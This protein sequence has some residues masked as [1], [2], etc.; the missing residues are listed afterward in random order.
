MSNFLR[1]FSSFAATVIA[2]VSQSLIV[3]VVAVPPVAH[4]ANGQCKWEGGPGAPTYPSCEAEDCANVGGKAQCTDAIFS[5]WTISRA[6]ASDWR[7]EAQQYLCEALQTTGGSTTCNNIP[8]IPDGE[9]PAI[10]TT[11]HQQINTAYGGQACGSYSDTGWATYTVGGLW[12]GDSGTPYVEK[13]GQPVHG[14]RVLYAANDCPSTS[15]ALIG[16]RIVIDRD[17]KLLCPSDY[18]SRTLPNGYLACYIPDCPAGKKWSPVG[19]LCAPVVEF[20]RRTK[21]KEDCCKVGN[22]IYPLRGT[23]REVVDTGIE[24]AGMPFQLTYDSARAPWSAAGVSSIYNVLGNTGDLWWSSFHRRYYS[25]AFNVY[26]SFVSRGDG[27]VLAFS[28]NT[29]NNGWI[30][31]GDI[32]D[33]FAF[34]NSSTL[35]FRDRKE[36]AIE[37]MNGA[38]RLT[39]RQLASG[40]AYTYTYSTTST[41]PNIAPGVNYLLNVSDPFGHKVSF[42]YVTALNGSGVI[43]T[44]TDQAGNA[45]QFSYDSNSNLVSI[46]WPD[47]SA[48]QFVYENSSHPWALT[49]IVDESAQR[50]STFGYDGFG[51]A[52]S[53]EHAG[54][55]EHYNVTYGTPPTVLVTETYDSAKKWIWRYRDWAPPADTVVTDPLGGAESVN[56]AAVLG[57]ARATSFAQPGTG[58]TRT[59]NYDS[60]A[61]ITNKTDFNGNRTCSSYLSGRNL[62]SIRI[63][64]L[65]NGDTCPADLAAYAIPSQSLQ[66][67]ITTQWHPHWDF[68]TRQAEPN[69][70][71]T[72][73]Y[74][75][76]PDPTNNNV[77]A[78]CAPSTPKLVDNNV[79]VVLCKRVEQPTSDNTGTLG[80]SVS[81]NGT[82]R[83]W[84]YTY[85]QHGRVLIGNGP[86]T[87]VS[88]VTT[89]T[90]YSCTTG[91]QCGQ[92]AT[93][94]NA[95]NQTTTYNTY[96]AFGKP[97]TITDPN[98]VVTTLTY[99]LRQ[100]LTSRL[101]SGELTSFTYFPTGLLQRVTLP[102]ETYLEYGYDAAHRL[103]SISDSEGNRIVYTL[104]ASSNRTAEQVYD[105]SNALTNTRSRVF[106]VLNRVSQELSSVGIATGFGYDANGNQTSINAP[107]ARNSESQYDE[108]NRLTQVTDPNSGATQF[109]Y[110]ALDQLISV[111]DPSYHV[112]S[113]TYNGL[114]D[115]T[116]Q[117]SPDTGTTTNTYDSAGNVS[118]STDARNQT[119]SY[120][121]DALNRVTQ[122][123]YSDQTIQYQYDQ[124]TNAKGRLTTVTDSSGQTSWTYDAQGRP[125]SHTQVMGSIQ[126]NVSYGYDSAGHLSTVTLPSGHSVQ[127]GYTNGKV[128]SLTLDNTQMILNTVLYEPFGPIRQWTWGNGTL[129][130]RSFDEDGNL[131]QLDSAGSK[132]LNYDNAFR[133]TNI[134]DVTEPNLSQSYN[135]DLLDRLTLASGNTLNQSWSYDANGNRLTQGGSDA[136][137]FTVASGSNQLNSASGTLTYTYDYDAVGNMLSDGQRTF[138][139]NAAGRM[140]TATKVGI[141]TSYQY[142]A[143]GQRVKK[144]NATQTTHFVYDESGHLLGE[145]DQAGNLIQEI[146]WLHDIP[147][148]SIRNNEQGNGVGVFYIHTDHLNTPRKMTRSTDNAIVW[149]FDSDPF[150]NGTAN[151]DPDGNGLFVQFNLRMPGQYF[152][153]ETGFF[154]NYYR[155]YDPQSGR[156]VTS[157]PIGLAGG[158]FSTYSYANNNPLSFTD[159]TGL[160]PGDIFDSAEAARRD[161]DQFQPA[162]D[163]HNNPG[164]EEYLLRSLAGFIGVEGRGHLIAIGPYQ[165]DDCQWSWDMVSP[166]MG[167]PPLPASKINRP[168]F[169]LEREA[170]WKA[171]AKNNPSKYSPADLAKMKNGKA[172]TGPDGHPMELH[173]TDGTPNGGLDP[174]SRTD[175]R[176]GGNYKKNHP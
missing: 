138:T 118:T 159:P 166:A 39:K 112:T 122:V 152:D 58:A 66:R 99:D 49:G 73:V 92:V 67:K 83:I 70:I 77:V 42:T 109:G 157:D 61:N 169:K 85:N 34:Y 48:R 124:G 148:A 14:G 54:G 18:S 41:P 172:P 60:T 10:Y 125:T 116:Q 103:T 91:Y 27:R 55:V 128:T 123:S 144:S 126:K 15:P 102:D 12:C 96:N 26:T 143:L 170:F 78:S 120:S 17:R 2:V 35:H 160:A 114:G 44:V 158:S 136:T 40:L 115:L 173:H 119:A 29:S 30:I 142:N 110:N 137:T 8:A 141:T 88:D 167:F 150:G 87:D 4:A 36:S 127:Y 23:K 76:Q 104:D 46:T 57:V 65:I 134:T 21:A 80:F 24:L 165:V 174:M 146:V 100:R 5:N 75:G 130:A 107:L 95:L 64:G 94:K 62:E 153:V 72:W 105:A 84:T 113:Y 164:F 97:L 9:W 43:S 79:I 121:Y 16:T 163:S 45:L 133:I 28:P 161:M 139:Y 156:Y 59:I 13:N 52:V 131:T 63:E 20:D 111:T 1:V 140:T 19:K 74:N 106:D 51:R 3:S 168:K 53:T 25:N 162:I 81:N 117:V 135:Y 93:I 108:L 175:H 71:T 22:P 11:V 145:Y 101:V 7:P 147:V 68:K 37:V 154:H 82:A 47:G 151:E 176:L 86:R 6:C 69:K 89:Y 149:R 31:D 132:S 98:G 129:S 32:S 56:G 33:S 38:G 90:Y 50:Y 171:Q 155:Y